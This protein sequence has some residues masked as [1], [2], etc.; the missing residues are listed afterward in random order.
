[1]ISNL[2]ML[3][4]SHLSIPIDNFLSCLTISK[5]TDRTNIRKYIFQDISN[6]LS[7]QCDNK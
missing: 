7:F 4:L 2:K 6:E 1:M 5:S 3:N